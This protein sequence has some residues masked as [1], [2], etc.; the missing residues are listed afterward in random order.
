M[1]HECLNVKDLSA[2]GDGLA[3][4][5]RPIQR[6]LNL[7]FKEQREVFFPPGTYR[8]TQSLRLRERVHIFGTGGAS[9]LVYEGSG[10]C[11]EWMPARPANAINA[12][13]ELLKIEA[14]RN[15]VSLTWPAAAIR[16]TSGYCATVRGVWIDG[17]GE[18]FTSAGAIIVG[19]N[20]SNCAN[21]GLRECHIQNCAGH[22]IEVGEGSVDIWVLSSR[23]QANGGWGLKCGNGNL[24]GAPNGRWAQIH[25]ERCVVEGNGRGGVTGS[26]HASSIIRNHFEMADFVPPRVEP[27]VLIGGGDSFEGLELACNQ[28]GI[29]GNQPGFVITP[30][31]SSSGLSLRGNRFT[32]T[33]G[34]NSAAAILLSGVHGASVADNFRKD[35]IPV[36]LEAQASVYALSYQDSRDRVFDV[37]AYGATGDGT[38]DDCA[39]INHAVDAALSVGGGTVYFPSGT[40]LINQRQGILLDTAL[41]PG[42]SRWLRFRGES[43]TGCIVKTGL[44]CEYL[45]Q[46]RALIHR[47][48]IEELT[49]QDE[50]LATVLMSLRGNVIWEAH[51]AHCKFRRFNLALA[52]LH[53]TH[54]RVQ[55]CLFDG[56]GTGAGSAIKM[57]EGAQN[58]AVERCRFLWIA[59]GV[60]NTSSTG[61]GML[62]ENLRIEGCYFDLGW[63]TL[64]ARS[65]GEGATVT[66]GDN[67]LTDIGSTFL[68]PKPP[69]SPTP[70]TI[71]AGSYFRAMPRRCSGT[72]DTSYTRLQLVD[73]GPQT[74]TNAGIL[75]G[76]MVRANDGATYSGFAVISGI[77]SDTILKVEEWLDDE[78]RQPI[79]P[80][81]RG[82][83]YIVYGILL[84]KVAI[85]PIGTGDS[86]ITMC[87]SWF[88]LRGEFTRPANGTR[89]EHIPTPNYPIHLSNPQNTSQIVIRGNVVKRGYS[90]QI[91]VWCNRATIIENDVSWGQDMGITINTTTDQG[92][93][94]VTANR[95]HQHGAGG[96]Y[97]GV[98]SNNAADL[99][100]S[101]VTI[102]SN[103]IT[104]TPWVN[105]IAGVRAAALILRGCHHIAINGNICDGQNLPWA[106][107]GVF[108]GDGA[109]GILLVGNIVRNVSGHAITLL[110][111]GLSV[112][113][114]LD[115]LLIPP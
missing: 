101:N 4:D 56:E 99:I 14:R 25:L 35:Q 98:G 2:I 12:T 82:C 103:I 60:Q 104:S 44:G 13:I 26:F 96:V 107:T 114:S 43:Q 20:G 71:S 112:R 24:R 93:T 51:I 110:N 45:V 63:Y 84:G 49:F 73:S 81:P 106:V 16:L 113:I 23:L 54:V 77:E 15:S 100:G 72:T 58:I 55:D 62:A 91:S 5:T 40:Y 39:A 109:D 27:A 102:N 76:E 87:Y 6:T 1:S 66:Y 52:L 3:D 89:Y 22:G 57:D 115:N 33:T 48:D 74:F 85:D 10:S 65:S 8:V 7:A 21:S 80:P 105:S 64:P 38:T 59:N 17:N 36:L 70:Q 50:F 94:V 46:S 37:R 61:M 9:V 31:Y 92:H 95:I 11:L 78:T 88:N 47:L 111:A 18:G 41:P 79:G 34:T 53:M 97:L 86:N 28:V 68:P 32:G 42:K 69:S 75:I 30:E 90:D 19:S 83:Q 67:S 108:I 29:K